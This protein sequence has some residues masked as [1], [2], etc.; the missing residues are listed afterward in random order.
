MQ[1]NDTIVAVASP[2]GTGGVGIVRLSGSGAAALGRQLFV[3][4]SAAFVDFKPYT[5]HHGRIVDAAGEAL[6]DALVVFMPAPKSFT[7][8]DVFEVQCH[9]G[10]CIVHSIVEAALQLGARL[11]E[12]GEFSRRA[13]LNGRMDLTQA[14]AVAELIAAP[15]REALRY[16][17]NKLDGLLGQRVQ[18]LHAS[19]E[20]LRVQV[21]VAVDF[22]EDE[23][24]CLSPEDF[25]A[26]A[27]AV[28]QGIDA[29]LAGYTRA[30]VF[31]QGAQVVLAGS[32]NV[33]KSSLMN[34]LLG[35]SRALVTDIPGTTRD[36]LE[37]ML[38]L[39]GMPVRL[40]DTAGLRETSEAVEGMGVALS[41]ERMAQADVVVLVVDGSVG[42]DEAAAEVL[43][44]ASA[45]PVVVVWNKADLARPTAACPA[46]AQGAAGFVVTSARSGEGLEAV[47]QCIRKVVLADADHAP[48]A[49]APN[50]RQAQALNRAR[51]EL[52]ALEDDIRAGQAY[53]V[54][55]VRLDA[56]AAHLAE[57]VGLDSPKEILDKVFSTFCIG[58]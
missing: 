47:A 52:A 36:F 44:Q 26:G 6:D 18:A 5:L 8:E 35:R 13:L 1:D 11:A 32:V 17:L 28:V 38:D 21:C 22:P 57:V 43:A 4:F 24:E 31:Q 10:A 54:C 20:L 3:P 25:L 15:S 41:R 46:W 14:E 39:D 12:R 42:A 58:K 34:A 19:L 27:G 30:R 53:D 2:A 23:V 49:L 55:A 37:E 7:G 33:G 45:V 56:A 9:G 48:E 50:A 51:A 16:G 29:L 40:V